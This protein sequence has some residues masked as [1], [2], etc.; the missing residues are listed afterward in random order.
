MEKWNKKHFKDLLECPVCFHTID[1]VPIYQCLNGHVVCKDCHPKLVNCPICRDDQLYDVPI[2]NLKLEE[3][4]Q[5]YVLFNL[6]SQFRKLPVLNFLS[7]LFLTK[8]H[9]ANKQTVNI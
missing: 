8:K 1:S 3:I 6:V 9:G 7:R 2:R 5:R 4:V